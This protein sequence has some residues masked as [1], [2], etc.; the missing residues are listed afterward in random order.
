MDITY[1]PA[2]KK[3][4]KEQENNCYNCNF[5]FNGT[6]K[7][8]GIHIGRFINKKEVITN[9]A[10]SLR[11]SQL[12]LYAIAGFNVIFLITG[13]FGDQIN[14]FDIGLNLII[15]II[16]IL[17]AFFIH[18]QSILLTVIP[19]VLIILINVL[20]FIVEPTSLYKGI[21]LKLIIIGSLVY[22]IYL[23]KSAADFKKE[24]GLKE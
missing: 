23:I 21:I 14:V 22:S 13:F 19:L 11:K 24:F 9:S 6:E 16:F 18:R 15:A 1:C 7:E 20:N 8:K 12:I 5:P 2:Y 4:A 10:D 17:C 3:E